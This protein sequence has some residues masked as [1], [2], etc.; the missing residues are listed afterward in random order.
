MITLIAYTGHGYP[1]EHSYDHEQLSELRT[2]INELIR[3]R[4]PFEVRFA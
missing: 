2:N 3:L 4:I 1:I